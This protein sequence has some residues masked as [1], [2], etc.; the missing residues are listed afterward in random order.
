MSRRDWYSVECRLFRESKFRRL[1]DDAQLALFYIWGLAGDQSPE[2]TWSVDDLSAAL[3]MHGRNPAVIPDTI[4]ELRGRRW[5]DTL[6]DGTLAAHDWDD[7]QYAASKEILNAWEA[8]RKKRWRKSKAATA[9][10]RTGQDNTGQDIGPVHV[11]DK[12]R[13][14]TDGVP[15]GNGDIRTTCPTCGDLVNDKDTNVVVRDHGG[16]LAHRVCPGMVATEPPLG[17]E[18][19]S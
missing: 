8:A 6:E 16:Q 5:L 19:V 10:D 1:S 7:H 14:S 4:A 3:E 2:A 9:Q 18:H 13:T 12:S 17:P 11:P 15:R